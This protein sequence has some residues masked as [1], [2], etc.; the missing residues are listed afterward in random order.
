MVSPARGS[1]VLVKFPFSDLSSAKRRPPGK[2]F[3][4]NVSVIEGVVGT[5]HEIAFQSVVDAV[6]ALLQ[7]PPS[8]DLA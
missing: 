2:L 7:K 1:V 5:L 3:T 6:V 4:A 8:V